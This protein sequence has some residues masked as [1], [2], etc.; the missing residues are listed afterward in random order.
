MANEATAK[1]LNMNSLSVPW[2]FFGKKRH[3]RN[4]SGNFIP[5]NGGRR[6]SSAAIAELSLIH[7]ETVMFG[8]LNLMPYS[9]FTSELHK[10]RPTVCRGLKEI[11]Q[12][13]IVERPRQSKYTINA[14]Y[15]DEYTLTVYSFLYEE[16]FDL[17]GVVR[18]LTLN[19]AYYASLIIAFYLNPKNKGEYFVGGR[20]RA[21]SAINVAESTAAY[22]ADRLIDTKIIFRNAMKKD[23]AGNY[24]ISD[25]KGN[26]KNELTVYKV[27]PEI[28]KRCRKIEA[29]KE[30]ARAERE[31][32]KAVKA[33]FSDGKNKPNKQG[34]TYN[35]YAFAENG[36]EKGFKELFS[37][38]ACD[39]A[40]KELK[41]RYGQAEREFLNAMRNGSESEISDCEEELADILDELREYLI[42]RGVPRDE[43]PKN[44]TKYIKD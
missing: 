33:L 26:S 6:L 29:E 40:V 4:G 32:K 44:L 39:E 31:Q 9:A 34:F 16:E 5:K 18:K 7:T 23:S 8:N 25:G 17:G 27:N 28:L 41:Q 42:R 21:S 20:K 36:E 24:I 13:E 22:V 15:S 14:E 12:N 35:K 38:F 2:A 30:K 10:S 19:E 43:I 37:A 11:I 1:K 3:E